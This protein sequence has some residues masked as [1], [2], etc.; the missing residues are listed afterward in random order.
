M[1]ADMRSTGAIMP[2]ENKI[3]CPNLKKLCENVGVIRSQCDKIAVASIEDTFDMDAVSD[4]LTMIEGT[5][6][7]AKKNLDLAYA[8]RINKQ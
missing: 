6:W 7:L 2:R 5:L 8:A 4:S 3:T 1:E